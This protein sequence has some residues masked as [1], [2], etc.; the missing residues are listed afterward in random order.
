MKKITLLGVMALLCQLLTAQ[1]NTTKPLTIGDTVPDIMFNSLI[2]FPKK[3]VKL[4]EFR[5]KVVI[6]DFWNTYCKTCLELFPKMQKL[7]NKF[8][9]DLQIILVNDLEQ[10]S[11]EAV[12][13]F[14]KER[15]NLT[16]QPRKIPVSI[17]DS[18]IVG[19]FPHNFV[20]HYV[21][22]NK[23]GVLSSITGQDE[24]TEENI[25]SAIVGH[26]SIQSKKDLLSF[27][28]KIPLFVSNNGGDGSSFE[29]RS[30]FTKYINGAG[31]ATGLK[32]TDEGKVT[33]FYAINTSLYSLLL[34]A[35][36]NLGKFPDN[37]IIN[38]TKFPVLENSVTNVSAEENRYCYDLILPPTKFENV[39]NYI[40]EDLARVFGIKIT[41]ATDSVK[42]KVINCC[43][44]NSNKIKLNYS[45]TGSSAD[46]GITFKKMEDFI[47]YLNCMPA[48]KNS[49]IIDESGVKVPIE[50]K[51][52]K[53]LLNKNEDEVKTLLG[54]L[55][56]RMQTQSRTIEIASII[57]H[58]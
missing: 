9:D 44:L 2:N 22:I 45:E 7:Q 12:T 43:A 51:F 34:I 20:P 24:L 10:N 3:T 48:L 49:P 41:I 13:K 29:Y 15:S 46:A 18:L 25:R 30:I 1:E 6:L 37:Q 57:N 35:Y 16:S 33:R 58:N 40:K 28:K 17:Y 8:P 26:F 53:D 4:S 32:R 23:Q 5:G 27:D 14:I 36:P 55:G 47:F 31:N 39:Q 42:A 50:Y 56:F 38:T 11:K 54:I 21:W 52:S 19:L